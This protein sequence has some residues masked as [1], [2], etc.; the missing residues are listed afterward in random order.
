MTRKFAL[1]RLPLSWSKGE[2]VASA[3]LIGLRMAWTQILFSRL[4]EA[5][6][7]D[8]WWLQ[9]W[10]ASWNSLLRLTYRLHPR[11]SWVANAHPSFWC[12]TI[13]SHRSKWNEYKAI[14][15]PFPNQQ[16]SHSR[17]KTVVFSSQWGRSE[18]PSVGL[19]ALALLAAHFWSLTC[20]YY[21]TEDDRSCREKPLHLEAGQSG[22]S[23]SKSGYCLDLY[24]SVITPGMISGLQNVFQKGYGI[25]GIDINCRI[26]CNYFIMSYPQLGSYLNWKPHVWCLGSQCVIQISR[27]YFYC[28]LLWHFNIYPIQWF[29]ILARWL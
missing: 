6:K 15:Q 28:R 25:D 7:S 12:S 23:N 5:Q 3:F 1:K 2:L 26:H 18:E 29:A 10:L 11:F 20:G 27:D 19:L 8:Y 16:V 14:P 24:A 13:W 9:M 21:G 22:G 4:S 17:E